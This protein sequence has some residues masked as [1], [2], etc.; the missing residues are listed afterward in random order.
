VTRPSELAKLQ[1]AFASADVHE[2][3]PEIDSEEIFRAVAG[4]LDPERELA[5][6]EQVAVNPRAAEAWRLARE[7]LDEGAREP[8]RVPI[9][10]FAR[11]TRF[12]GAMAAA[13][14]AAAAGLVLYLPADGPTENAPPL[15]RSIGETAGPAIT[16][17]PTPC[18][19]ER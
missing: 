17:R 4:E 13:G 8:R 9:R 5:V 16:A 18:T 15:T 14:L 10:R 12:L 1:Q 19:R 11:R 6:I 3:D 7:L 2:N